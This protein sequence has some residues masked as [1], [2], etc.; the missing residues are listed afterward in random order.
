M[1]NCGAAIFFG[2]GGGDAGSGAEPGRGLK[3]GEFDG[4][5]E[6]GII[7]PLFWL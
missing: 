2:P 1:R 6:D 7:K 4:G 5:R 3:A